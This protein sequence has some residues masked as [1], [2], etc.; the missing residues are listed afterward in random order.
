MN[1]NP[2]ATDNKPQSYHSAKDPDISNIDSTTET[3]E[4]NAPGNLSNID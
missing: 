4:V 3:K 2:I 1:T